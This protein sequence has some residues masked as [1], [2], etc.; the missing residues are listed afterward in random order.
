[1]EKPLLPSESIEALP[2][3]D[4]EPGAAARWREL[5]AIVGLVVLADATIY[6]GFGFSGIAALFVG[7]PILLTAGAPKRAGILGLILVGLLQLVLAASL[8]WYGS[9]EQVAIGAALT[10]VFAIIL[11]GMTPYAGDVLLFAI[12]L[13]P[14]GG[15]A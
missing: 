3:P 12:L 9:G 10:V 6:H 2:D 5:F 4:H 14:G 7:A 13:F 11:A 15:V 8:V 1:M